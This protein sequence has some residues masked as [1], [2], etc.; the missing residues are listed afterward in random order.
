MQVKELRSFVR[1]LLEVD[2][3]AE[4]NRRQEGGPDLEKGSERE[5]FF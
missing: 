2:R 4:V 5:K 1:T 3:Q